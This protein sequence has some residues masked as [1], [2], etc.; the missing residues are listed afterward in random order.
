M[1]FVIGFA[2]FFVPAVFISALVFV[3]AAI[4]PLRGRGLHAASG[5]VL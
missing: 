2:S 1:Y 5:W 3:N 4:V